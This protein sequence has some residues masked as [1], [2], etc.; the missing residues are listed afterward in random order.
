[1]NYPKR[2]TTYIERLK[3]V[4]S[5]NDYLKKLCQEGKAGADAEGLCH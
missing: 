3:E 4:P 1:M 2:I 5:T